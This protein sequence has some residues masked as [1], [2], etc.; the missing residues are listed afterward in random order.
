MRIRSYT[1]AVVASLA[2]ISCAAAQDLPLDGPLLRLPPLEDQWAAE[3]AS[4]SDQAGAAAI[5]ELDQQEKIILD[6][7]GSHVW[8][9]EFWDPW[10]G[11]VE[12][13]LS[14]TEGN[15]Q[16]FNVRFGL[17]AKH[18]TEQLVQTLEVTS[19]QKSAGGVTTANT[20]LVDGRLEWPMPGSKWN[21]YMH[22]LAE[23]D[24]F[25]AFDYRLSGDTG[26]GYELLSGDVTTLLGRAG[27]SASQ[28]IGGLDDEIK[29]ELALGG[30][31]KHKFNATHSVS[32]KVDYFPN[33]TEFDD[34]RLNSQASWEIALSSAWGLS[35]KLSVIDRYDSTPQGA[36]PNDLDYSTLLLWQF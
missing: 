30:E 8:Q 16:T 22:G 19:I 15:S 31:Y 25:K 28:E 29:P 14:G 26:F 20:A 23:R 12:L 11:S 33:V 4:P 7:P 21:Y 35:L 17:K 24:E 27:L 9:P 6:V 2:L 1:A 10:E 13:G 36:K 5:D 18:T 32:A 3:P 34:F